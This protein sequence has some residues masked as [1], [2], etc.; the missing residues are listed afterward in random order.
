[1][2]PSSTCF[3]SRFPGV[4]MTDWFPIGFLSPLVEEYKL[5]TV[6]SIFMDQFPIIIFHHNTTTYKFQ[7][8]FN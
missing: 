3:N 2:R 7:F 8:L 1:M 5:V 4:H 6:A